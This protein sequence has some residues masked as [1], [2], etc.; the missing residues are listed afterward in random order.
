V[1]QPE[2][3]IVAVL[4]ILGYKALLKNL[5]LHDA[6]RIISETLL[7]VPNEAAEILHKSVRHA[8]VVALDGIEFHQLVLSRMHRIVFAD[9]VL[10]ALPLTPTGDPA[11]F[12]WEILPFLAVASLVCRRFFD[13]GLPL[14]GAIALGGFVVDDHCFAGDAILKALSLGQSLE[15]A[16]CALE[17]E[18]RRAIVGACDQTHGH[19]GPGVVSRYRRLLCTAD[20]PTKSGTERMVLVRWSNPFDEWEDFPYDSSDVVEKSFTAHGKTLDERSRLKM[21]NTIEILRAS[22]LVN[23][24]K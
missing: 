5:A 4:D 7:A 1:T 6:A 24:L 18:T 22:H 11:F 14:R 20:G 13:K 15:F 2:I 16:G 19:K 17:D 10:L 12:I 8:P 9:T 23:P 3:G 21:A